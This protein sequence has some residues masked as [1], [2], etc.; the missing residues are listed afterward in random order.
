MHVLVELVEAG[1]S[2][3]LAEAGG[4]DRLSLPRYDKVVR[5]LWRTIRPGGCNERS[6]EQGG[7]YDGGCDSLHIYILDSCGIGQG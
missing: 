2:G 4:E 3:G 6:G 7:K 5:V 1:V